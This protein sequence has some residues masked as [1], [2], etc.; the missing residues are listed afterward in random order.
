[1]GVKLPTGREDITTFFN[2]GDG[3]R[4][5]FH[6]VSVQTGTGSTDIFLSGALYFEM[7]YF[8]PYAGFNWT[9]TPQDDNNVLAFHP[10]IA[11][12]NTTI[13]NSVFDSISWI[14]ILRAHFRILS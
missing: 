8:I 12:P 10:Q 9:I 14:S 7:G 5:Y 4:E 6:D 3:G 1:L 11:D 2:G 13:V